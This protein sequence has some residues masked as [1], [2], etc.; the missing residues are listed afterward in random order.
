VT[1]TA[2]QVDPARYGQRVTADLADAGS[3]EE[4]KALAEDIWNAFQDNPQLIGSDLTGS[5]LQEIIDVIISQS[6][7]ASGS[8]AD[9]GFSRSVQI[10]RS[11]TEVQANE[12][13]M[14]LERIEKWTRDTAAGVGSKTAQS[15]NSSGGMMPSF[16]IQVPL[17]VTIVDDMPAGGD[18][19]IDQTS[20]VSKQFNFN[21]P[22]DIGSSVTEQDIDDLTREFSRRLKREIKGSQF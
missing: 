1:A 17:P 7:G 19:S 2:R 15:V 4:R 22:I 18:T 12:M 13:I 20:R 6:D 3:E 9:Q 10:A 14:F 16:D 11:I 5:D 8:E 21:G